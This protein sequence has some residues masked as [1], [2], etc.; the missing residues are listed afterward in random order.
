M[1]SSAARF[2]SMLNPE[3]IRDGLDGR[4]ECNQRE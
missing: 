3:S 2:A 1:E 4:N